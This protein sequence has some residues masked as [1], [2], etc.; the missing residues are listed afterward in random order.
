MAQ[1]KLKEQKTA[2]SNANVERSSSFRIHCED[3][4]RAAKVNWESQR[5][6]MSVEK[7]MI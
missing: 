3:M 7:V 5:R 2:R 6:G 1:Q 4:Q